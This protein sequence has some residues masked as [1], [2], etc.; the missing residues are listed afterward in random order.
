ML[1]LPLLTRPRRRLGQ[2]LGGSMLVPVLGG[3]LLLGAGVARAAGGDSPLIDAI[4]AG[5]HV[6]V[7]TLLRTPTAAKVQEPDGTTPLHWAVLMDDVATV[8]RLLRVG[9]SVK[10]ATRYGVT[11]LTLAAVNGNPVMIQ[12]LL[13]AGADPNTALPEGETVLMTAARTGKVDALKTLARHG[14]NVNAREGWLGETA[15][16]WAASEN[17]AAAV[18]ALIGLGADPNARSTQMKFPRASPAVEN[19][20]TMTFPQ[21]AWTPLMYAARQGAA[22]AVRA[23]VAGKADLD[24]V[25]PDGAT[26]VVLAVINGHYDLAAML[27]DEGADPNPQDA[28]GMG[29]LYAAID[30]QTLSWHQGRPN[31]KPS[32]ELG[33]LDVAARLLEKGANPNAALKKP[34]LQRQH[35]IGDPVLSEGSTPFIRAARF[36]DVKAMRLLLQQGANPHLT[37][38]NH[39]TALMI[40]AGLGTD[41]ATDEFALDPATEADAIEA[42]R[43]CLGRGVDVD[44]FNDNG[45][46]ALHRATGESIIRFLVANGADLSVRN[47]LGKTPL[48]VVMDRKDR[49]GGL[50][51]PK[52][53]AAL[54]ELSARSGAGER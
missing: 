15:L 4:K 6:A 52:A 44:A 31:P 32:G 25:N 24:A 14:A 23:L 41:R 20:I 13:E 2:G 54:R 39:N 11:P 50:R 34:L 21:G 36:G 3:L 43:I 46:T 49:N 33:P 51:Y 22:E 18:T 19:L 16:M 42:I 35:T 40:A 1:E 45:D 26:A 48:E 5:D 53:V 27:L 7:R 17:H 38:K 37:Q 30:M 47:K 9:A 10:T 8:Q 12:A 29:A 28:V